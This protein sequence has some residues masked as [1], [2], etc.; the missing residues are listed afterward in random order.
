MVLI[1]GVDLAS[2]FSSSQTSQTFVGYA[3]QTVHGHG[4]LPR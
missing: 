1:L 4:G 2:P 3:G